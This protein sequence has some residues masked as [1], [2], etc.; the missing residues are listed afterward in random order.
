[1]KTKLLIFTALLALICTGAGAQEFNRGNICQSIPGLS[2]EQ[3]QKI[4]RIG[5]EHQ[6][7]M[8]EL[9]KQFWTESDQQKAVKLKTQM[10]REMQSHYSN[11]S[12]VLTPDQKNWY[13]QT[14]NANVYARAAYAR[15]GGRGAAFG[16]GAVNGRGT[17]NGKGKG[18]GRGVACCRGSGYGR[19]HGYRSFRGQ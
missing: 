9:R 6:Q 14:C 8:D 1:M 7:R 2:P 17:V 19:G 12:A 11:I 10:N 18:Y 3:Q 4:D 15:G 13:V 16:R 5:T